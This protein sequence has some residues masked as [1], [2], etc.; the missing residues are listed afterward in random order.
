MSIQLGVEW[1]KQVQCYAD[2]SYGPFNQTLLGCS[3]RFGKKW[4]IEPALV[5]QVDSLTDEFLRTDQ[6]QWQG[7]NPFVHLRAGYAINPAFRIQI[8]SGMS[9]YAISKGKIW[10]RN[11]HVPDLYWTNIEF[12]ARIGGKHGLFS[13]EHL[14]Q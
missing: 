4:Y 7:H 6:R 12:A 14:S 10:D 9:T 3:K 5:H 2:Y 13:K 8:A 11:T 1:D